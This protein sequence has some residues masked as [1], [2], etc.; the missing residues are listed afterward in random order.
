VYDDLLATSP[1]WQRVLR[2]MA[3]PLSVAFHVG[4]AFFLVNRPPPAHAEAQ[5]VEMAIVEPEPP[6]EPE[7]E[8]ELE[9][10]KEQ[11]KP[12]EPLPEAEPVAF[13]ETVK[14]AP[15]EPAEQPKRRIRRIQGLSQS[16][17]S[18]GSGTNLAVRA[19]TTTAVAATDV[20]MDIGEAADFELLP[21]ASVT[22]QPR[23]CTKP[24]VAVP[25]EAIE[26]EYEGT[27]RMTLDLDA[28]GRVI[29]VHFLDRAQYGVEGACRAAALKIRCKPARTDGQP[30]PVSGMPHRCTIRAL[31]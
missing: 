9:L 22:T 6:P 25:A 8:P 29:G 15:P 23:G 14:E 19:G 21:V 31:D 13:E 7:P 30:V 12:P 10:E 24:P 20:T 11:P 26:A 27:I 1:R 17:F 4:L 16:S 5:W 3:L 2:M 28:K 18:T